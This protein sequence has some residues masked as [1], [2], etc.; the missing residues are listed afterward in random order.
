M[1]RREQDMIRVLLVDDH[2]LVRTGFRMILGREADIEIVGEAA[3]AEEGLQLARALKPDVVLMD[4]QLPGVSGLEATERIVRGD[5]GTRVIV[6]T[7]RAESPFPRRLLEAGASGYL[8]KAGP[9]EELVQAVRS[10]ARGGRFLGADVARALALENL[11]G[12]GGGTPFAQL[13]S[14]EIEVAM[15]LARGEGLADIARRL[16]LSAKTVSTYKYRLYEKLGI[17][18]E[19]ALAHLAMQHGLIGPGAS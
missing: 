12:A 17:D 13:S 6:L 11:P 5:H 4:L 15:M 16:N 7:A 9:A 3:S 8:T 14:R 2:A 10:V 18:N 1:T 19:V